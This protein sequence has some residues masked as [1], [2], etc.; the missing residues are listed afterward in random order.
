M[1]V[2]S[3]HPNDGGR[4]I[5]TNWSGMDHS[6]WWSFFAESR[7][8]YS[9]LRNSRIKQDEDNEQRAMGVRKCSGQCN[10]SDILST[11]RLR[12]VAAALKAWDMASPHLICVCI[13][14]TGRTG[15]SRSYSA[16]SP[17]YSKL[18]ASISAWSLPRTSSTSTPRNPSPNSKRL[19]GTQSMK[20]TLC[21]VM[22]GSCGAKTQWHIRNQRER[23]AHLRCVPDVAFVVYVSDLPCTTILQHLI[24]QYQQ[25]KAHQRDE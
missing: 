21:D 25:Q 4:V 10:E 3:V 2:L 9:R 5:Y 20:T 8:V 16:S 7:T 13:I 23:L 12:R 18:L 22:G 1:D 19:P 15:H 24:Q 11:N 14:C 6:R 17:V